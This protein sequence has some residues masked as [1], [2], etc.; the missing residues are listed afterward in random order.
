MK[1]LVKTISLLMIAVLVFGMIGCS[2][3]DITDINE[4]QRFEGDMLIITG[5]PQEAM[6]AEMYEKAI[7]RWR[8]TYKGLAYNPNPVNEQGVKMSDEDYLK[9]YNFCKDALAKN[10]FAKYSEDDICDGTTYE[11]VYCDTDGNKHVIYDGYC[12][13][14]KEL[15]EIKKLISKYRLE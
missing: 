7:T 3:P 14:N 15:R 2:K 11:F 5:Y 12:Y 13:D 8:L 9:I 1:V 4:L 6:P 10:K